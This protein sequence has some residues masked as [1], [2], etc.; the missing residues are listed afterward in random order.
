MLHHELTD[1][2]N[3]ITP[4]ISYSCIRIQEDDDNI[5]IIQE[6]NTATIN[7]SYI[8]LQRQRSFFHYLKNAFVFC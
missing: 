1:V 3:Y 6:W 4:L 7:A 5:N 8:I 2:Y